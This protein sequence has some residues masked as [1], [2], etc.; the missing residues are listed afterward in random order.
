[1]LTTFHYQ[2]DDYDVCFIMDHTLKMPYNSFSCY[3]KKIYNTNYLLYYSGSIK[4]DISD[5]ELYR[6]FKQLYNNIL[7]IQEL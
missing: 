5:I 2:I 7:N 4:S 1:M 3:R 6:Y